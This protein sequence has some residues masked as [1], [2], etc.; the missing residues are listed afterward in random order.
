MTGAE[1]EEHMTDSRIFLIIDIL[2]IYGPRSSTYLMYTEFHVVYYYQSRVFCIFLI[3]CHNSFYFLMVV[4][5]SILL[6]ELKFHS[7]NNLAW[8]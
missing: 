4:A 5:E 8:I 7:K 6:E 2:M 1:P 3:G